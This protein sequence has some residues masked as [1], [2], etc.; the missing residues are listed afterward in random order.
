MFRKRN[1]LLLIVLGA[2]A[3]LSAGV[4]FWFN[5][6]E[7]QAAAQT[8]NRALL[9][10]QSLQDNPVADDS[11]QLNNDKLTEIEIDGEWYIGQ[12]SI[13][14]LDLELPV[15]S[16][17]NYERLE[18]APCRYS[19]SVLNRDLVI[20]AHNYRAHFGRLGE[21]PLDTQI[22]F[23]D[24]QGNQTQYRLAVLDI[25]T[26]EDVKEVTSDQYDLT[27]FTCTYGGENRVVARCVLEETE[28]K[29]RCD[30]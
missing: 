10:M 3:I 1:G 26:P 25:L 8:S 7:Q 18:K 17:W 14:A 23:R 16:Q 24:V 2:C 9:K 29:V 19:G 30:S 5:E 28:S 6:K 27:L 13:P 21:L 20:M 11:K 4:L 15:I 12:L 22:Y